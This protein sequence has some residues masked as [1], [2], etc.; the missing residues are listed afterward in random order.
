MKY[1]CIC[2]AG[3][4]RFSVPGPLLEN[5]STHAMA[6]IRERALQED[7]EEEAAYEEAP[8]KR[9]CSAYLR[10]ADL[11]R[12]MFQHPPALPVSLSADGSTHMSERITSYVCGGVTV[13]ICSA[14][15][16]TS[17]AA[18]RLRVSKICRFGSLCCK[19]ACI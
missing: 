1:D 14:S 19:H 4:T 15:A 12:E 13:V 11:P 8:T 6:F 3:S 2:F 5:R 16:Y 9:Q 17:P 7:P 10:A 18:G